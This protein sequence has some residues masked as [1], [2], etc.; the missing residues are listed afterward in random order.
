MAA[1]GPSQKNLARWWRRTQRNA[2][3]SRKCQRSQE[4]MKQRGGRGGREI[5]CGG[6]WDNFDEESDAGDED[7]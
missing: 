2:R 7:Y 5:E 1:V 4:T 6:N 3:R